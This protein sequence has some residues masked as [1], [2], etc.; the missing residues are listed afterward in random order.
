MSNGLAQ[1][2]K[3]GLPSVRKPKKSEFQKLRFQLGLSEVQC[4]EVLGVELEMVQLWDLGD[5]APDLALRFLKLYYRQDLS[6]HG[7]DWRG[8]RFSRGKLIFGRLSF[9][10]RSLRQFPLYV[11]VFNRAQVASIRYSM[12]GLPLDQALEIV[13]SSQGFIKLSADP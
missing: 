9:N 6:G 8:F 1:N 12:D 5:N 10:P 4:S 13:F 7:Q 11:E 2:V 3:G